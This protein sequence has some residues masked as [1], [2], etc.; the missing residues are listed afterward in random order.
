MGA[1][2]LITGV[3][4]ARVI[5]SILAVMAGCGAYA[6]AWA[7]P[8]DFE[9]V[10]NRYPPYADTFSGE[11]DP[12]E[13]DVVEPPLR[14][15]YLEQWRAIRQK[16]VDADEAGTPLPTPS[17]QCR[18]EGVPGIMGAHYALQI[19]QNPKLNQVTVLAEFMMQARRIYLG[20]M[21]PSVDQIN[22]GYFG[23]S[24]GKWVG[25][26]LE[27]TTQGVREDVLYEDIPHSDDMKVVERIYLDKSG[28][29]HNDVTIYDQKYLYKPYQFTFMYKKESASYKI[30]EF[31][32]DNQNVVIEADGTL[33]MALEDEDKQP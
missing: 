32:C 4:R 31:V 14:P 21:M 8:P 17:S 9:G 16:R 22:P 23:Y 15:E 30:N 20:E 26:V 18:P 2:S 25:D 19:M 29:L 1:A 5:G 13:L 11:P 7:A 10:W 33:G 6:Q 3:L 28:I 12:P 24:V 27:V